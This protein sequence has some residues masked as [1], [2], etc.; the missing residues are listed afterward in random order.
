MTYTDYDVYSNSS[1]KCVHIA[2]DY[3]AAFEISFLMKTVFQ[4]TVLLSVL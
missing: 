3:L 1:D 2:K 4:V